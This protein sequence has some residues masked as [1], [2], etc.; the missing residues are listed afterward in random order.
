MAEILA[1]HTGQP[2][3]Q[4]MA[5]SGRVMTPSEAVGQLKRQTTGGT[6]AGACAPGSKMASRSLGWIFPDLTSSA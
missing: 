6:Y 3:E 5:D 4:V 1:Q 2:F